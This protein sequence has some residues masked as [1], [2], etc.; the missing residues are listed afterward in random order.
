MS[1]ESLRRHWPWIVLGLLACYFLAWPIWRAQFLLEIWPTEG[2]NA[3]LQDAAAEGRPLYPPLDALTA[4]N[5]PPLSFYAVGALGKIFG[6]NLFVGRAVSIAG[7]LCVAIEIFY[8]VRILTGSPTGGL[9]GAAWYVAIMARN[10]TTYIATNDPQLAGE[11]IMGAALVWF[12]ARDKAGMSRCGPLLLMVVGG[13]WKHNLVAIP[14]TAV[15]WL[16]LTTGRRAARP[17]L[18]SGFACLA[19]L[20]LCV[21]SF[22]N[23]FIGNMLANRQYAFANVLTNIGHLQWSALALVIWAGW[24]LYNPD[25]RAARFTALHIASGL[26]ACILQWFGHGVSGNAEF[27]LILALGIG[28][29]VTFADVEMSW[30]GRRI[31]AAGT[32]DLMTIVL[33][34][35][36]VIAERQETALLIISPDFRA[37]VWQA[38]RIAQQDITVV[39]AIDGDVA[40]SN[41]VV[42]RAAG[43]RFVV[44]EFKMEEL[45]MT[46]KATDADISA[47]IKSRGITNFTNNPKAGDSWNTSLSQALRSP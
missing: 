21:A 3:Y 40:C 25:L 17:I 32:R 16:I 45:V 36:L 10:S 28:I 4:N 46:G 1:P 24:A 12:L 35:R 11:A 31:G 6:D 23:D 8:A 19:G 33:V 38:Q 14:I 7:L 43:K 44:D 39:L 26:L 29:G 5:Y 41:K 15:A 18:L 37:T 20:G 22:G 9:F 42:C 13:F 47:L 27:D 30:L 34:L 2:W